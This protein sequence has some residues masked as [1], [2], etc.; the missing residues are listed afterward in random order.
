VSYKTATSTLGNY[1]GERRNWM[2]T[3]RGSY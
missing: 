2:L 3:L 1:Y